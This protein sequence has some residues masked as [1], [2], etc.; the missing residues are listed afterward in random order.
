MEDLVWT[1]GYSHITS[2]LQAAKIMEEISWW[3]VRCYQEKDVTETN[4]H[5]NAA[6]QTNNINLTFRCNDSNAT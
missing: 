3:Y 4:G 2:W 6:D 5:V 1:E